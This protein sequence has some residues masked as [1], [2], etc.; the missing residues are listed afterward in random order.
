MKIKE[1]K[2]KEVYNIDIFK[3]GGEEKMTCPAC[4]HT[5]KKKTVKCFSWNHAKEVGFCSH[6][7]AS[8]IPDRKEAVKYDIPISNWKNNTVLS[9]KVCKW[10]E[11][12]GISQFTLREMKVSEGSVFMPQV[13]KKVNAIEF[14]YFRNE[15]IVNIKYRDGAKNF[16]FS[17]N[18]ELIPYNYDNCINSSEIIIVEG[19]MDAL[20]VYECGL[21]NVISVPNGAGHGQ[22]N[23]KYIDN[24][25]ELFID[26][27]FIIA[28]DNDLPGVNLRNELAARLGVEKCKRIDLKDCKDAN[29]YLLKYG[30]TEL[31]ECFKNA[32]DFPVD[33]I[34]SSK[35]YKDEVIDLY[36]RGL[37]PGFKLE[38]GEFD[39][40]LTFEFGRLYT[41]TGIPGHGKSEF[42]DQLCVL[43][44]YYHSLKVAFFSP[45][46]TPLQLHTSKIIEKLVGKRFSRETMSKLELDHAIEHTKDNFFSILPDEDMTIDNI[47][48]KARHLVISR[49]IKVLVIDPYNTIDHKRGSD[50]EH[51][52]VS[53]FMTRL[54]LF[55]KLNNIMIFLVAHPRKIEKKG[56]GEY[57][58]PTLYDIS[59]SSH[60]FNK[61]DFG[62]TV[63]RNYE[64]DTTE[65]YIQKVKF[66]HLGKVGY[67]TFAWN[68]INGRYSYKKFGQFIHENRNL[69]K[70]QS[71][72]FEENAEFDTTI[73]KE[74]PF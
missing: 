19:E 50:N 6:C 49:G 13:N 69:I 1:I 16:T 8:F 36:E 12:R 47:L 46:N 15:K 61:T 45:E 10:F 4:S 51:E 54:S 72:E 43:L 21:H 22:L 53:K 2:T 74:I 60:F 38:L 33:G 42:V 23:L 34:F 37:P 20:A 30:K 67:C 18:A 56:N 59:G 35:D 57:A 11:N 40:H 70:K 24:C 26:K 66:K 71:Y 39:E 29:E 52:Y 68:H 31:Q 25:L 48:S 9:E 5:R 63:Y 3:I 73:E 44:N 58:V 32:K 41:F 64:Q 17:K 14:N 7:Q 55:A 65:I 28:T 62:I 27:K